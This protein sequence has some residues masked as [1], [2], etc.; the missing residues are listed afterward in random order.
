MVNSIYSTVLVQS[1][2]DTR[3]LKLTFELILTLQRPKLFQFRF[4]EV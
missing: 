4:Q 3:D 2:F 1:N